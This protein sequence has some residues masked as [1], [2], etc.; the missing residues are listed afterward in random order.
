[1]YHRRNCA[2]SWLPTRI[3]NSDL[4][5]SFVSFLYITDDDKLPDIES[6]FLVSYVKN[7]F[8]KPLLYKVLQMEPEVEFYITDYIDIVLCHVVI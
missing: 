2:S 3:I 8:M 6:T 5:H 1:M 4:T 7:I